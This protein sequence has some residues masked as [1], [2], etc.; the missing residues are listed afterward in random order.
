[1]GSRTR[2]SGS[3]RRTMIRPPLQISK[4]QTEENQP[5]ILIFKLRIRRGCLFWGNLRHY[6]FLFPVSCSEPGNWW[7]RNLERVPRYLIT[8]RPC[9]LFAHSLSEAVLKSPSRRMG[10]FLQ[11]FPDAK[12]F[13]VSYLG[14]AGLAGR[15]DPPLG[16][17]V[18]LQ[19]LVFKL[20]VAQFKILEKSTISMLSGVVLFPAMKP[21]SDPFYAPFFENLLCRLTTNF[22][23]SNPCTAA[24]VAKIAVFLYEMQH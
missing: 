4:N 23:L 11:S 22:L 19:S 8:Q 1:M 16:S 14:T 7:N 20:L 10:R 21:L 5:E 24:A 9:A 6:I 18:I 17:R 2:Q 3:H 13:R 15:K 12:K